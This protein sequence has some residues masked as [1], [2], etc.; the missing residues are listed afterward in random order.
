M[1]THSVDVTDDAAIHSAIASAAKIHGS[2]DVLICSAGTS[3]P[4]EFKDTT[5]SSF[6]HLLNLN[7]VGC[8]NAVHASLPFM[9]A[10]V[11]RIVLISSQAGQV[12]LYGFTAYSVRI[13]LSVY[14]YIYTYVYSRVLT[15]LCISG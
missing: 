7:I 15:V 12:G 11:G 5:S 3:L 4:Q 1:T 13:C 2:I 10:S 9:K 8:R 14:I 6:L